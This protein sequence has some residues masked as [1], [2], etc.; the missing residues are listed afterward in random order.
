ML[1]GR[2]PEDCSVVMVHQN[3]EPLLFTCHFVNWD[4]ARKEQKFVDPYELKKKRHAELLVAA[5]KEREEKE[6]VESHRRREQ[7][8]ER[9]MAAEKAEEA[10]ET[11]ETAE[12]VAAETVAAAVEAVSEECP[13]QVEAVEAEESE[14]PKSPADQVVSDSMSVDTT[15]PTAEPSRTTADQDAVF[16]SHAAARASGSCVA[17]SSSS[18]GEDGSGTPK[19][20]KRP[21]VTPDTRELKDATKPEDRT[22]DTRELKDATKPEDRG[23]KVP[24]VAGLKDRRK[25]GSWGIVWGRSLISVPQF[26]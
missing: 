5:E 12:T 26:V 25:G 22:P 21:V 7:E 2:N 14:E 18:D 4:P 23:Y 19:T 11:A 15:K 16:D 10:A 1:D 17:S 13:E 6:L 9:R 24:G 3:N 20:K 8:A